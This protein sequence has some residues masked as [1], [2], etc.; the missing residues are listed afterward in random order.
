M[1]KQR[2]LI[3]QARYNKDKMTQTQLADIMNVTRQTVVNWENASN[4]PSVSQI[5]K[6]CKVLDIKL[7]ELMNHLEKEE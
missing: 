1:S 4:T 5:L 3:A 2:N 7:E 6:L